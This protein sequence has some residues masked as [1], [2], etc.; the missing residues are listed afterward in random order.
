MI[1]KFLRKS[2]VRTMTNP[3]L[4]LLTYVDDG[5]SEYWEVS[6]SSP[7]ALSNFILAGI[8]G[9]MKGP[10][11]D[12][13]VEFLRLIATPDELFTLVGDEFVNKSKPEL[14]LSGSSAARDHFDLVS[15]TVTAPG[16]Y[17]FG[18]HANRH[19]VFIESY[20][21]DGRVSEVH[22]DIG[23]CEP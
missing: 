14:D 1:W 11:A 23:C 10:N 17:E 9:D 20:V 8:A 12:A 6:D 7:G 5:T 22:K 2:N 18:L 4:G 13:L 21:R 3:N 15:L 16:H 19:D